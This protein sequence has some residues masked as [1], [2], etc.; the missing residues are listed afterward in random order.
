MAVIAAAAAGAAS[1]RAL[2]PEAE[3]N[4]FAAST[5]TPTSTPAPTYT[6]TASATS[7]PTPTATPAP[8]PTATPIPEPQP[9]AV[10]GPEVLG[11]R[12]VDVD[13]SR[14]TATAMIGERALYT[15][16]VTTGKDGWDTPA[17]TF[18][19]QTRVENETM[20]SAA[21][22]AEEY[23]VLEDVLY[24]QYFTNAGHALHLNWWRDP[25]VFGTTRS[26]HGCVGMRYNDALFFWN[27]AHTGT[28][29]VIHG[30]GSTVPSI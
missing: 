6:A 22:G 30:D 2:G 25:W 8:E 14:Q 16:L 12:W 28:R 10:P 29:V 9:P 17:G 18:Y 15:A 20:T 23:Y 27:F 1:L 13:L 4:V 24:T 5:P 19:I 26:S 21:I 7:T 3:W 11:E